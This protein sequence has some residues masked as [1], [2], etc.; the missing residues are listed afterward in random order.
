MGQVAGYVAGQNWVKRYKLGATGTLFL[1]VPHLM[2]GTT[3]NVGKCTTTACADAIGPNVGLGTYSTTQNA[4]E[5]TIEI[6][7]NPF[8][9]IEMTASGGATEGTAL[10]ILTNTSAS[11]GGTVLTATVQ[12]NDVDGGTLWR[13]ANGV[14]GESRTITT[15][16]STTS[17]TVTVPFTGAAGIA[18]GDMFLLSPYNETGNGAAG[19]DGN[20]QVQLTTNLYQ[21]DFTSASGTG[22]K[23]NVINLILKGIS[24]SAIQ[25]TLGDHVLN[26]ATTT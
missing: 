1:G 2:V 3:G 5:G 25:F 8:A 23:A 11:S 20:S 22:I 19:G 18:V 6:D 24:D 21:A 26:G 4:V 14:G 7:I 12:S 13:Y 9:V 15:H 17:L 10:A 16:T